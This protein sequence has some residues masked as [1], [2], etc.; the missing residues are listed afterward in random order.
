MQRQTVFPALA[1]AIAAM[2]LMVAHGTSALADAKKKAPAPAK[3]TDA[4]QAAVSSGVLTQQEARLSCKRMAGQMQI[5]I[6]EHRGGGAK[7]QSSSAAQG[8]QSTVVPLFGG[9]QRG[10]DAASDAARDLARLKAMNEILISRNCPHYDLAAELAM[11]Q[12]APTPRLIRSKQQG[13]KKKP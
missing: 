2:G 8:L 3:V 11:D 4:E 7:R 1:C 12:G 6:L 9:S 13:A 10:A 5:R